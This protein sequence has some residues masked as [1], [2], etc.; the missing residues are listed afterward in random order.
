MEYDGYAEVFLLIE[1]NF[2]LSARVPDR[3]SGALFHATIF[4][5]LKLYFIF[6]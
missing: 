5:I 3:I 6:V 1:K 4:A 2:L